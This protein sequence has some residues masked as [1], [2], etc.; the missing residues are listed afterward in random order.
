M[1]QARTLWLALYL[2]LSASCSLPRVHCLLLPAA[3]SL[4]HAHWQRA[5]CSALIASCSLPWAHCRR[6]DASDSVSHALPRDHCLRLTAACFLPRAFCSGLARAAGSTLPPA[7][8]LGG[9]GGAIPARWTG[10][11]CH[12]AGWI[13]IRCHPRGMGLHHVP[14]LSGMDLRQLL[15]SAGWT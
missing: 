10:R 3:C 13:C 2:G 5:F 4:P 8:C 12:P 7:H 9:G 6:L 1:W 11:G 15:F 14:D